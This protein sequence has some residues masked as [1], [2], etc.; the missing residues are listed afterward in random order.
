M[1]LQRF[2]AALDRIERGVEH[3]AVGVQVRVESAGRIVTEHC[4]HDV[5]RGSVGALA[6][7]ADP[8]GR[9]RFQLAQGGRY[10]LLVRVDDALVLAHQGGDGH[11][12]G[13]REGEIVEHAPIGALAGLAI[14]ANIQTRGFLA[15][16]Q[17]LAGLGMKV[18][19]ETDEFVLAC[20]PRKPQ[21]LGPI[22][23]PLAQD[24]LAFGVVITDAQVFL[25]ILP[26]VGQSVLCF[27]SKH[28][29][30]L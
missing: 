29:Q 22:A 23:I 24:L 17:P 3:D 25:E 18:L 16:R 19:T 11:R 8:G 20:D 4:G 14:R 5:A 10:G 7:L 26:G 1:V 21:L 2:P 12:L 9:E 27:G 6:V 28:S 13:R 30:R 15:H